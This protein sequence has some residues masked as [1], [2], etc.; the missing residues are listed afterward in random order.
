MDEHFPPNTARL[1]DVEA[2]AVADLTP[3][4]KDHLVLTAEAFNTI[5]QVVASIPDAPMKDLPASLHV[6]TKLLLRLSNDLRSIDLLTIY[7][8]PV[9]GCSVCASAYEVAYAIGYIGGDNARAQVWA[10][11]DDPTRYPWDVR[12][13]TRETL[14]ALGVPNPN[15]QAAVEYRVYRQLCMAKHGNPLFEGR[16]GLQ[17]R[18]ETVTMFN[19]PNV[20]NEAV[21]AA[22]FA[23]EHAA[24][25]SVIALTSF[26][27]NHLSRYVVTEEL[28]RFVGRVDALGARRKELEA[29]AI[30]EYGNED[31]FPGRW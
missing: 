8:Y 25:V 6:A 22:R 5:T 14:A 15:A 20:S 16:F 3:K 30:A 18:D 12:T 23:L 11:H 1:Q 28:T 7:G 27:Q 10:D 26:L 21:R 9:Q 2:Q 17:V 24:G 31:P 4:L 19:G 29:A 13:M